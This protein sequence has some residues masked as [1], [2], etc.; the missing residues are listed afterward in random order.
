MNEVRIHLPQRFTPEVAEAL[1]R[2]ATLFGY[3]GVQQPA[4]I[5]LETS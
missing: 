3:L 5:E 4:A 2:L 1:H